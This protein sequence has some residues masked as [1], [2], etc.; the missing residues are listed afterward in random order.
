MKSYN[1]NLELL[2]DPSIWDDSDDKHG[3]NYTFFALG[4]LGPL[5][6]YRG[7]ILFHSST[8]ILFFIDSQSADSLELLSM[9]GRL[10]SFLKSFLADAMFFQG[11]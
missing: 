11:V 9:V 3:V 10:L 5:E 8:L 7:Q 1:R 4:L 2:F 6:F